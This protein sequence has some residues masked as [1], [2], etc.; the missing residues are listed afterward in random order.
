MIRR[1][2][3]RSICSALAAA[4]LGAGC[5]STEVVAPSPASTGP[6]AGVSVNPAADSLL[7]GD[8]QQLLA[9]LKDDRG[10][11]VTPRDVTWES[12][13]PDLATVSPTGLVTGLAAGPAQIV[14]QS[15]GKS[16]MAAIT[17]WPAERDPV[18]CRTPKPEWIWCDD[19]EED[20][21]KQYFEYNDNGGGFVR[22]AGVGYAG[23]TGMRARFQKGQVQAG[24]LHLAFG[25][26]P[27]TYFRAV[28]R[29]V[30]VYRD[31]YW[32]HLVK[33]QAGWIG[34]GGNKLSR[35]QSLVTPGWAQAMMAHVWSGSAMN[36]HPYELALAPASGTDARGR[37]RTTS[38][39]EFQS[40]RW[41]GT[42]RSRTRVF[43]EVHVGKWYCV[44]ARA[45]LN[46]PV[47]ANGIFELWINGALEARV[48]G[49]NWQGAFE[50]YGINT[51]F[52][53]NYWNDGS[54]QAQERYFD[55]F[56]V[57]TQ[58]IGC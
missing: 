45:R 51:V 36:D 50:E 32:R 23:S 28:D 47:A 1:R 14:A 53:E 22:L 4:L 16:G 40:F 29:G 6:V 17:V 38:Y 49:I 9:V 54:P 11:V 56:V 12:R 57:S 5:G 3:S 52:L 35:A 41:L 48:G 39:N 26:T 34:G 44:E 42:S 30:I 15:E 58:R 46:D 21:L 55:N 24:F 13:N 25:K 7:V 27:S 31:I 8:T 37:V 10:R 43:D 33:F 2:V 19:F 20:R 18:E